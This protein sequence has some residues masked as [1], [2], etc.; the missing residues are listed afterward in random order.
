MWKAV[1]GAKTHSPSP[2]ASCL[3]GMGCKTSLGC[4]EQL[5]WALGAQGPLL[6][7]EDEGKGAWSSVRAWKRISV[8]GLGSDLAQ[9]KYHEGGNSFTCLEQTWT[10]KT[11]GHTLPFLL[12]AGIHLRQRR[13][14]H[15]INSTIQT[16]PVFK[17]PIPNQFN[18]SIILSIK[19]KQDEYE[20]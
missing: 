9:I 11:H 12:R 7:L 2:L 6:C 5:G 13:A 17:F 3:A 19:P 1:Q 20:P 15:K 8:I 16:V 18:L 10:L 4:R 14:N